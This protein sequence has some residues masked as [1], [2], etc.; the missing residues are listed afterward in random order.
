M[1]RIT[2]AEI[3]QF[4]IFHLGDSRERLMVPYQNRNIIR[5]ASSTSKN[6][7]KPI[8]WSREQWIS[9]ILHKI[10][11]LTIFNCSCFFFCTIFQPVFHIFFAYIVRYSV[12]FSFWDLFQ[13]AVLLYYFFYF[14][15]WTARLCPGKPTS[16]WSKNLVFL[17]ISSLEL[18]R[19]T[20]LDVGCLLIAV[21]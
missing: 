21:V 16:F 11:N 8:S 10:G 14:Y 12:H 18:N 2:L 4:I 3:Y 19:A 13:I 6:Y 5:Q 7:D 9:D 1:F 17:L 15:W 20:Y